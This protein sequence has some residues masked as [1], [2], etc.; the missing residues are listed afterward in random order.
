MSRWLIYIVLLLFADT[1]FAQQPFSK[2]IW[3]NE[4]DTRV[5]VNCLAKDNNG[6]IWLGT[7]DGLYRYNGRSFTH[8]AIPHTTE[9]VTA[10]YAY[11]NMLAVG[12]ENGTLGVWDGTEFT[13]KRLVGNKPVTTISAIYTNGAGVFLLSTLG[14]GMYLVYNNYCTQYTTNDGLSDNYIYTIYA[15]TAENIMAATDQGINRLSLKNGTLNVTNYTTS[16]GLPDNIVRAISPMGKWGWNWLGTHQAG[17]AFYCNRTQEIWSPK[18]NKDWVWGQVN[19]VLAL[20]PERAWVCT[21]NG[22][23]LHVKL[24]DT[25][26]YK[27]DDYQYHSQKLY[28]LLSDNAGNVWCGTDAG[29]KLIPAEYMTTL[30]LTEPY[31][32][33]ELTAISCDKENN[34]WYAIKDKLYC[35]P[36][37][38]KKA[39][40]IHDANETITKIFSDDN[41]VLWVGTFGDGLW[42][43]SNH[44]Q[45][46]K[47]VSV[48]ALK[49]E[50]ILDISGK[51]NRLW[52]SGLNG[53]QELEKKTNTQLQH[54]K[55]HN[56]RSGIGSDYVYMIYTDSHDTTW[57]ATDGAGVCAYKQGAYKHWDT[58]QGMYADVVYSIAEDAQGNIWTSTYDKGLQQYRNNG[59]HSYDKENGLQSIKVSTLTA[60]QNTMLV[61]HANGV[62]EYHNKSKAV[63]HFGKR[64]GVGLDSFAAILNL[65]AKD[66]SGNVYIPYQ[67]GLVRFAGYNYSIDITPAVNILSLN[68]FFRE[69]QHDKFEFPYAENHITIKYDG[70]NYVNPEQLFYRYKLEGYSDDWIPTRDES[71]TFPQLPSGKYK[72]VVQAAMSEDFVNHGTAT[73][74]FAIQKPFWTEIWFVLLVAAIVWAISFAYIRIRERNLKKLSLLQKERMLFEYENLKSQ[75]N[76]HFLFNSLNTLTSLIEDDKHIAAEYTEQLSDLYRNI[77]SHKDK[78]LITLAEEWK[79]V[80]N[81]LYIQKSRFG[82][83]LSMQVDIPEHTKKTKKVVPMALQLLLENAMKHNIVSKS[84]PLTI[85]FTVADNTLIVANNLQPKMSNEKGEGLGLENIK[86]RYALH[87]KKIVSWRTENDQFIVEIPLI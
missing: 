18:A 5:K 40:L 15:T 54:S 16:D 62:D 45:F 47:L 2:D 79:I 81:Y 73:R 3:L 34:I 4:T 22:Y 50:S 1:L 11:Q 48:P 71:V 87:T 75:V 53:V 35:Q 44:K 59:W 12:F 26:G 69:E 36:L 61:V 38:S 78:D 28:C 43:S 17:L 10:L 76:P 83:A 24:D 68:T 21:E 85:S 14:D 9:E 84:K 37:K 42:Y 55:L 29:L 39:M 46:T 41:N 51:D 31:N 33:K 7:E 52:V 70:I 72:F 8:I 57:M 32:L 60:T 13:R 20:E 82:N 86:K 23:L 27:I 30:K 58:S 74:S 67:G 63:R 56:K 25:G 49:K 6:Y 19:D 65:V 77:L 80:D 64:N 66:T